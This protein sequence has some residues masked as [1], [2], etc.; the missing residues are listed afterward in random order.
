MTLR[1]SIIGSAMAEQEYHGAYS[2][3]QFFLVSS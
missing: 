3:P 1:V 2:A